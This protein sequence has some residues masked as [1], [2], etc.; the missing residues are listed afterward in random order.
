MALANF[1][2]ENPFI[3]LM[4]ERG[5]ELDRLINSTMK[6]LILFSAFVIAMELLFGLVLIGSKDAIFFFGFFAFFCILYNI[7][8]FREILAFARNKE[9]DDIMYTD[10]Y[11]TTYVNN[12]TILSIIEEQNRAFG[13]LAG[14]EEC[15]IMECIVGMLALFTLL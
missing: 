12:E 4:Q 2:R 8:Y 9:Y 15:M 11:A 5:R 10:K 6:R 7:K 1:N 3:I 13:L 14:F